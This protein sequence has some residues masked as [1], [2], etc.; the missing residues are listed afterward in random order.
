MSIHI[1]GSIAFDRIMT[2]P[3]H[4]EDHLLPEKLHMINVCFLIDR[5]EEKHGGTA[6]NIAYNLSLLGGN[7]SIYTTVG[8]DYRGS[9]QTALEKMNINLD[10]VHILEDS[11][12]ACAY[13][14]T[15][16]KGNQITGF[17]LAALGTP[18][19]PSR[20]PKCEAGDWGIVAP[21]NLDDMFMFP[22]TF[23]D[24]K[25]PYI[26]DPGQTIPAISKENHL[27]CIE[28]AEI[29]IG[30]DYEI[31]LVTQITEHSVVELLEKA[32]YVIT[33]LGENGC[34]IANKHEII[35]VPAP[36]VGVV[37]DPTGA[38]DSFRA[39][40]LL[41][42][43]KGLDMETSAKLAS[44]CSAFCI[45]KYGTQEHVY[46]LATLKERYEENYGAFPK[47]N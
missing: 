30:N 31:E 39:G 41:G 34:Q 33:T 22:K 14:T 44:I 25:V 23:K 26:Y 2:F 18:T 8:R 13:I 7:S 37:A 12:T 5:I 4:F 35:H 27:A 28:G 20:Y 38:G 9:F 6:A 11:L 36:K 19:D 16:S 1:S 15:D 47:F 29:F 43:S 21:G 3:G 24:K 42:L 45:E 17:N 10:A 32:K 40:L 46:T